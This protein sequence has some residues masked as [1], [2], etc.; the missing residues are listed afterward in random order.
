MIRGTPPSTRPAQDGERLSKRVMQLKGCSR[1]EAEL[2]IEG[3]WVMVNGVVVE[4]PPFRVNRQTV[5]IDPAATQMA[6]ESVTLLLHKPAGWLDGVDSDEDEDDEAPQ[7][8]PVARAPQPKNARGLLRRD[9]HWAQDP[10]STRI[11]K[12]HFSH[13]DADVPLETGASGLL[14]FTQDWRT[15]RKLSE[16]MGSMEHELVADVRGEVTPEALQRI[17]R[18]LNDS[19]N[20]MPHT[21]FSVSSSG[22]QRSKLRFAVKGAHPGLVAY[23]CDKAGLELL[24][25]RRIRLGR[26]AL[27]ELPAGQWRY[28]AA[29]EKF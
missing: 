19:R 1:R 29:F 10:S 23:L 25:L 20:A 5:T 4:D 7:R 14:V 15:T 27:S 3:G 21:K 16:D 24:A 9:T 28:L 12:R 6:T 11:L 17:A 13:L 2:Y 18:A 26:I 8:K 22:P